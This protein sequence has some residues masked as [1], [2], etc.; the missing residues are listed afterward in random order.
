MRDVQEV[1]DRLM[2]PEP[3]GIKYSKD[4]PF[5][6]PVVRCYGCQKLALVATI[7]Q[8]GMCPH[9]GNTRLTN[10]RVMQDDEAA[11]VRQWIADGQ[12]DPDWLAEFEVAG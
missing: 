8:V 1:A 6:E 2:A 9:C 11:Q 7:K 12:C 10:V 5:T 3:A 4:G